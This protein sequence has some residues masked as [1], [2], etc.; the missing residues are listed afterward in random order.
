MILVR[1]IHLKLATDINLTV[2]WF[3]VSELAV[4]LNHIKINYTT[5]NFKLTQQLND[6]R[7]CKLQFNS[8]STIQIKLAPTFFNQIRVCMNRSCESNPTK[9]YVSKH[10]T[11]EKSRQYLA[12]W[13]R[14]WASQWWALKTNKIIQQKEVNK[15]GEIEKRTKKGKIIRLLRSM[16]IP[17]LLMSWR[18][19]MLDVHVIVELGGGGQIWWMRSR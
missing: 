3:W 1:V 14:R 2:S 6:S 12:V 7:G 11:R 16:F 19:G 10:D 15:N 9:R 8:Q 5:K 4:E 13:K 18:G 17:N